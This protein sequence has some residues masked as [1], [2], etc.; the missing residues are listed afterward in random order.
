MMASIARGA[1]VGGRAAWEACIS[2]L[3]KIKVLLIAPFSRKT[4][5][6]HITH[7]MILKEKNL[8][9]VLNAVTAHWV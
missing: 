9:N 2:L 4:K 6:N 5:P 8:K 1:G 7:S 3:K